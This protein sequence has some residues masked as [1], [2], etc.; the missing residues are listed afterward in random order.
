MHFCRAWSSTSA[1]LGI[2][3][4]AYPFKFIELD[5]ESITEDFTEK[6]KSETKLV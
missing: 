3:G 5:V 2:G 4:S 1:T 6:Y